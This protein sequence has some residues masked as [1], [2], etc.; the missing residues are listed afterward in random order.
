MCSRAKRFEDILLLAFISVAFTAR[1]AFSEDSESNFLITVPRKVG[2][3][4]ELSLVNLQGKVIGKALES[5]EPLLEPTWSPDGTQLAFVSIDNGQLQIFIVARDQ[6]GK[7]NL[8]KSN[9]LERNPTWSPDS[10]QIAW[11]RVEEDNKHSIW[12]MQKDG[13]NAKCVSDPS[14]MCSNPNWSPDQRCIAFSTE[15]PD[16]VNFRL[17]KM[18]ADGSEPKELYKELLLRVVYPSWAPDG[19]QIAFGGLGTEGR[20]QLCICDHTGE[21]F[22][23]LTHDDKQCSYASWSPDGQYIA[24]VRFDRW[25]GGYLPVGPNAD[26]TCPPGDLMLLDTLSGESRTLLSGELLMYGPRPSW[27]PQNIKA[28]NR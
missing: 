9:S 22:Q 11:T 13:S 12:V 20:V 28:N 1:F 7:M 8:T 25:P 24:Y 16:E 3:K 6:T 19:K 27:M 23:Q 15:R 5:D 14:V 2:D 18:N 26:T 4:Y 17:W 10:S 21:G